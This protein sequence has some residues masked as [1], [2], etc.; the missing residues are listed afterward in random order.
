MWACFTTKAISSPIDFSCDFHGLD[1]H[2][3]DDPHV[4]KTAGFGEPGKYYQDGN[5]GKVDEGGLLQAKAMIA[6]DRCD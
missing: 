4:L 3:A 5:P 1:Y 2:R 6:G